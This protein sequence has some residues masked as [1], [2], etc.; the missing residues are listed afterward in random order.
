MEDQKEVACDLSNND[1]CSKYLNDRDRTPGPVSR[2]IQHYITYE[3]N[4][5]D[6]LR[7]TT[8]IAAFERKY[9]SRSCI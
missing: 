4:Y 2:K 5:N 3:T 7:A 8:F 9:F 6:C 1:I